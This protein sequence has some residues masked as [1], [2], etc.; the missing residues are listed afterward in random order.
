MRCGKC[1]FSGKFLYSGDILLFIPVLLRH[2]PTV[3]F[4]GSP[5]GGA[6]WGLSH[7]SGSFV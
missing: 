3:G 2:N 4:E 6:V 1:S 5:M 7:R